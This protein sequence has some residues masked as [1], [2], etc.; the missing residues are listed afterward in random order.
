MLQNHYS[1]TLHSSNPFQLSINIFAMKS[2]SVQGATIFLFLFLL[3]LLILAD[4]TPVPPKELPANLE[5]QVKSTGPTSYYY[6]QDARDPDTIVVDPFMESRRI[7]HRPKLYQVTDSQ[8]RPF[9]FD[10]AKR[11]VDVML[12]DNVESDKGPW[13][14]EGPGEWS[15]SVL[16]TMVRYMSRRQEWYM[17]R[18]RGVQRARARAEWEASMSQSKVDPNW[19]TRRK[20]IR[21][22]DLLWTWAK[23]TLMGNKKKADVANA[24]TK[25]HEIESGTL[26]VKDGDLISILLA[27]VPV[28]GSSEK[29]TMPW[30]DGNAD[31]D[32]FRWKQDFKMGYV[33]K[34][35]AFI[36]AKLRNSKV[37]LEG[38][39]KVTIAEQR[40]LDGDSERLLDA[41]DKAWKRWLE[42]RSQRSEENFVGR[43][44][45]QQR[46]KST[47]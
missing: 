32:V 45:R 23:K 20:L 34:V 2:C 26:R 21:G 10:D 42:Y 46:P 19:S 44:K 8:D 33:K 39:H 9:D 16:R 25:V 24:Q 7:E 22:M 35:L 37:T 6:T 29:L 11:L 13:H 27:S 31:D 40:I 3:H 38:K 28:E 17:D 47:A 18:K 36:W 1:I 12:S 30:H 41:M 43:R 15:T 4:A 5:T 14:V